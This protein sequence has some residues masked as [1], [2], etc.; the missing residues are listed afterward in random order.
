MKKSELL[1]KKI[2]EKNRRTGFG[3]MTASERIESVNRVFDSTSIVD[4]ATGKRHVEIYEWM[5]RGNYER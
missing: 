3:D 2:E 5:K 1:I 4:E